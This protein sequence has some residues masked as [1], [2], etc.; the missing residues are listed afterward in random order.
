MAPTSTRS[1]SISSASTNSSKNSDTSIKKKFGCSFPNCGKSF[2]RSE[3]LHRHALNHKDGNNTCQRCSAH[4]RRRDL[5]DR[6]MA[7]HKEKDDEA[8]G[9]GLGVLATRKRLWRDADGNIVN[10]RRPSYTPTQDGNKRRQLSQSSS[11]KDSTAS[12]SSSYSD[13]DYKLPHSK[14]KSTL[15]TPTVPM[16]RTGSAQSSTIVVDTSSASSGSGSGSATTDAR[17]TVED[18]DIDQPSWL[19]TSTSTLPSPPISEPQ[20]AGQS[21]SPELDSLDSLDSLDTL[22][23]DSWPVMH[24]G[25]PEIVNHSPVM[26]RQSEYPASPTWGP[27]PFQTFMGAMAELPY[28]DIFKPETGL[29]DWQAWNSQVLM[30]RCREEKFEGG[31][32]FGKRGEREREREWGSSGSSYLGA[33][34]ESPFRRTFGLGTC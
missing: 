24:E 11:R 1:S 16:S 18:P 21:P 15:L 19:R 32:G 30:S 34:Q 4:F 22:Y 29:Y 10:A 5:L 14:G 27:Q 25:L 33:A 23:E 28:D 8:G 31:V 6:H 2:S 12:S 26:G 17:K 13:E 9:E 7:R 3:H 20:S